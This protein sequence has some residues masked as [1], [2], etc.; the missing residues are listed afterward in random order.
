MNFLKSVFLIR[1]SI[2]VFEL[3]S[4]D[5]QSSWLHHMALY[6]FKVVKKK[7]LSILLNGFICIQISQPFSYP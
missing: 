5:S 1:N 7:I 6:F 4:L 2:F 3:A